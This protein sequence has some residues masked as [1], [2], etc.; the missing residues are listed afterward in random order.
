MSK[1][2]DIEVPQAQT[3]I[4]HGAHIGPR[5]LVAGGAPAVLH[6]LEPAMGEMGARRGIKAWLNVNQK[7]GF[8]CPSCA[9]PDPDDDR[10]PFEFCE[11]GAKAMA[12][13]ATTKRIGPEFFAKWSVLELSKQPDMWLGKQGRLTHPIVLKPGA[14]HYEPISWDGAFALLASE[15][16]ALGS[17]DEAVFYTSGRTGNE[18]AFLYQ[19]F[20]RQ[21][22]T[23]NLPDCSNMCHES[24]GVGLTETIG[25]GKSTVTLEDVENSDALFIFGQNPGTNHPRMLTSLQKAARKGAQIVTINPLPETGT[26]KFKHPQEPISM[27]GGGTPL[28]T[29]HL[30][31]R[32]NGDVALL[33]AIMKAMIEA[34]DAAPG[35]AL[36]HDFINQF[37][38]GFDL[39]AADLRA[40]SWDALCE[41]SGLSRELITQAADV[42]IK[43]KH[44]VFCWA[45]GLTQHKNGVAN[46]QEVVNLALLRGMIGKPGAGLCCVRGHS[47][48]QGDRTMGIWERMP[49]EWLRALGREF[50]FQPPAKHGFDT[51]DAIKAM[52]A[53]RA[54]VFFALGGN[55]LS[56]TPDTEFT[57]DALRACRLTAHVSTKLNRSHLV[58]GETALILPCL[59]RTETDTQPGGEQ[60]VTVEDSVNKVHASRGVFP[61]A[62]KQ[63]LSETRIIARLA[64]ATLGA[65]STV[66]WNELADDYDCIREHISR[67]VPG[68]E[69]FNK[70]VRQ[71]GGFFLPNPAAERKFHTPTGR[72]NFTRHAVPKHDLEPGQLLLMTLR[73]HDQFNTTLY[74]LDD[75]YRG[76]F[77]GRRIVFLNAADMAEQGL[78]AGQWVDI[79]SHFDGET[80][81]APQFAC[82]PYDIPRRSAGAYYPE[83]NVL[84]PIG[85]VAD[86]SNTP[87]S[88][89]VKITL[90]PSV[91]QPSV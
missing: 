36:D 21:F 19:L 38:H 77:G 86:K 22:G 1:D 89:S 56:A 91:E 80:R 27:L 85:S 18:A 44:S 52:H 23:N 13:E 48:V 47:N 31:V 43:S 34:E 90:S 54:R 78:S 26:S 71:P 75:R 59:G 39:F 10:Q 9:W 51:V 25:I 53:G 8:D 57:A 17:P 64:D 15:L 42:A 84:V 2:T 65:K 16:N 87:T 14:T 32:V 45:M 73:S 62:S 7:K 67:V 82:V 70:R 58:H 79:T 88:K 40:E 72:A 63:L 28:E 24:S 74:G 49:D 30:P 29:L 69:D 61:P 3:P 50:S 68:F 76:V 55:F 83:T 60:F 5:T 66:R 35:T 4:E 41:N 20:V 6:S 11:N 46:V 33:K 81:T 37:T 12:E